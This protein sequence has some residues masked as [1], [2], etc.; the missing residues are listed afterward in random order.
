MKRIFT[1]LAQKWPEYLLEILVLII[2]IYGAFALDNWNESRKAR[3]VEQQLLSAMLEDLRLDAIAFNNF[4][5]RTK[6]VDQL[7]NL[8]YKESRNI[9]QPNSNKWEAR[10]FRQGSTFSSFMEQNHKENT[11]RISNLG[12][13]DALIKYLIKVEVCQ[14]AAKSYSEYILE[15]IRPY[16]AEIGAYDLDELYSDPDTLNATHLAFVKRE[17]I[18]H[19]YGTQAFSNH[20]FELKMRSKWYR[21][22]LVEIQQQND[23]LIKI[24]EEELNQ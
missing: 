17:P 12:I 3:I 4:I 9:E 24:I 5:S 7:H 16:L 2:G 23:N 19:Q 15:N 20:L 14:N 18:I 1:T 11:N 13:R 22:W 10:L 6:E 8:L 21:R